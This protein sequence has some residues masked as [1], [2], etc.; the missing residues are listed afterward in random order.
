M[1]NPRFGFSERGSDFCFFAARSPFHYSKGMR[2]RQ[3]KETG[4]VQFDK[5]QQN[6]CME[7]MT[8]W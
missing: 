5:T 1:A 8:S 7:D 6:F 3:I 4:L 2:L